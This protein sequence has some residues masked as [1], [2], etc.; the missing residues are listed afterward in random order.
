MHKTFQFSQ[1]G[2][3]TPTGNETHTEDLNRTTATPAPVPHSRGISTFSG[4]TSR[5]QWECSTLSV[6][7]GP[8]WACPSLTHTCTDS[9]LFCY[10]MWTFL[11]FFISFLFLDCHATHTLSPADLACCNCVRVPGTP[12]DTLLILSNL[13]LLL[14]LLLF[15]C[16]NEAKSSCLRDS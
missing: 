11:F 3:G 7:R 13:F 8:S 4:S 16:L 10:N 5:D 2:S 9:L 15:L 6:G 14:F 12:G 1:W